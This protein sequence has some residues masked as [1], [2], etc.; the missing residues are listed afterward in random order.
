[1]I[2]VPFDNIVGKNPKR[3]QRKMMFAF[4]FCQLHIYIIQLLYKLVK[5]FLKITEK[6]FSKL[7]NV[8]EVIK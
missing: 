3:L 1:M 6:Y 4:C 5:C 7:Y 8:I 2:V